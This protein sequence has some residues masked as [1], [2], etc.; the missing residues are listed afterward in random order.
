M[1]IF[2]V[3]GEMASAQLSLGL[4]TGLT[5]NELRISLSSLSYI[6][7]ET[8]PGFCLNAPVQYAWKDH[9]AVTLSPGL[10]QKNYTFSRTGP[11]AGSYESFHNNYFQLPLTA[12]VRLGRGKWQGLLYVGGY[13]AY[14]ASTEL[15]GAIPNIAGVMSGITTGGQTASTFPLTYYHE[16]YTFNAKRDNRLEWGW[17]TGIGTHYA[18]NRR[19][20]FLVNGYL[21]EALSSQE[22]S[23]TAG[24]SPRYN[25]TWSILA[26]V[27]YAFPT[28]S[29]THKHPYP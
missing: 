2:L 3:R 27:M 24:V 9:F 29:D 11:Y 1:G 23:G 17:T 22:R 14:W 21:S 5:E 10:Y 4:T 8:Q 12:T 6:R 18:F 15:N 19:Y 13:G 20:S 25:Q 7:N 26:G 28:H 16:S